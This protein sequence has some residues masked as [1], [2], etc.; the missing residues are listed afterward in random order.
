MSNK[1]VVGENE[2]ADDTVEILLPDV[3]DI[4]VIVDIVAVA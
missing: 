1:P 2:E 4:S 3:V